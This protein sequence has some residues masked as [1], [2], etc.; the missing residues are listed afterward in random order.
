MTD[1]R[2][3]I[4]EHHSHFPFM[5]VVGTPD[6]VAV[7]DQ[8]QDQPQWDSEELPEGREVIDLCVNQFGEAER[9]EAAMS[10]AA[11]YPGHVVLVGT[12][13]P[14][15]YEGAAEGLTVMPDVIVLAVI[16]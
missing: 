11:A 3:T 12:D 16:K 13:N 4:Q 6:R 8:L 14:G 10:F 1:I 15:C 9:M 7:G 2:D 5:G